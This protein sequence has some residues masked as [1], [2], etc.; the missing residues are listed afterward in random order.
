MSGP[1]YS[2]GSEDG[3]QRWRDQRYRSSLI[4][5]GG[6]SE[7]EHGSALVNSQEQ[8]LV[9]DHCEGCLALLDVSQCMPLVRTCCPI[10]GVEFQVLR[11]FHHF[12][13]RE[14]LAEGGMGAVYRAFDRELRREV[15]VKVLS[16]ECKRLEGYL[17]RLQR[18]AV[19]TAQ[20]SHPNVVKVFSAG[21]VNGLYYVSM[22]LLSGGTVARYLDGPE[23]LTEQQV[24]RI[25]EQVA[26]GL[27]A[28]FL[29][30]LLHRD[31]KPGNLMLVDDGTV[32]VVDF[33]LAAPVED[34]GLSAGQED[35]L[36]TPL[37]VAPE[38][39]MRRG[40]DV[41]S[42]IYS[43]GATL[44]HL[45]AGVPVFDSATVIEILQA[46]VTSP[47]PSVMSRNVTVSLQ[48]ARLLNRMLQK[49]PAARQRDYVEVLVDLRV[50]RVRI[51]EDTA[52]A[53]IHSSL[54][55]RLQ[56]QEVKSGSMIGLIYLFGLVLLV[57][58]FCFLFFLREKGP[59]FYASRLRSA[60][61][62]AEKQRGGQVAGTESR[63]GK[64]E[65]FRGSQLSG[66][67]LF[68]DSFR[69][70]LWQWKDVSGAMRG[71]DGIVLRSVEHLISREGEGWFTY[72]FESDLVVRRGGVGVFFRYR[73]EGN[74]YLYEIGGDGGV[75]FIRCVDGIE[76]RTTVESG[77]AISGKHVVVRVEVA[78]ESIDLFI[79]EKR[80]DQR[81]ESAIYSGRVGFRTRG[82]EEVLVS[83]VRVVKR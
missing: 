63:D 28:S 72:A 61:S 35:L 47:V 83:A 80:V 73:D 37:Y 25:G 32:K 5:K 9:V 30:G 4:L 2:K 70:G 8:G 78:G 59:D 39:V 76:S 31:V 77:E 14:S 62:L 16:S 60:E 20:V 54:Q 18:E 58:A 48:T 79:D 66:N 42:D 33:G 50:A 67:V 53:R 7:G 64:D 17:E 11:Q 55:G 15:A 46:H 38:K 56:S 51:E 65:F 34:A 69:D 82:I 6:A 41:R 19:M 75:H 71:Q 52:A 12:E 49:D 1:P 3:S 57:A 68:E 44:Y 13:M 21:L 81:T 36:G 74:F 43:L 40:E 45:L 22:E 27:N 23:R 29:C 24:L 10:C 26:M